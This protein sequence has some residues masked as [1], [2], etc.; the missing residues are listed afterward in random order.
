MIEAVGFHDVVAEDRT[1]Q[2]SSSQISLSLSLCY[3]L[4]TIM[5]LTVYVSI[6]QFLEVLQ[7]ELDMVEKDKDE[8]L[9]DFS[10]VIFLNSIYNNHKKTQKK[11]PAHHITMVKLTSLQHHQLVLPTII[12][13]LAVRI[14]IYQIP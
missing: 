7:R 1:N 4:S 9:Q 5:V 8:F 13:G 2:V 11:N 14:F 10:E 6:Y 3:P 12:H